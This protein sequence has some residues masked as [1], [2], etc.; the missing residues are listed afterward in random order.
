MK[1]ISFLLV[2]HSGT[3]FVTSMKLS[4]VEPG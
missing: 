1:F 3:E 2:W 4:Y